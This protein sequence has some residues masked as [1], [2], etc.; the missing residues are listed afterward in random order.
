MVGES[1]THKNA[2]RQS[3]TRTL[4]QVGPA[5]IPCTGW[6]KASMTSP[7]CPCHICFRSLGLAAWVTVSYA[8]LPC[9][10]AFSL[11]I[12]EP[13][14]TCLPGAE[15]RTLVPRDCIVF[16]PCQ[17]E[18]G[19]AKGPYT[20]GKTAGPPVSFLAA[21]C[22]NSSLGG[23]PALTPLPVAHPLMLAHGG[24]SPAHTHAEKPRLLCPLAATPEG[25]AEGV[26]F[27]FPPSSPGRSLPGTQH[28]LPRV[29]EGQSPSLLSTFT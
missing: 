2:H 19:S 23:R 17:P 27:F 8:L 5:T 11:L 25:K 12:S 6:P 9:P 28:L 3:F 20:C 22:P 13:Y 29:G 15:P 4:P 14:L 24:Q 16:D 10:T 18:M 7:R 26:L 21:E 1:E